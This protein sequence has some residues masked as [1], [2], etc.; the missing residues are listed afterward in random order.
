MV[1]LALGLYLF[2]H[3]KPQVHD[4]ATNDGVRQSILR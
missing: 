3:L 1:V 4:T 2:N